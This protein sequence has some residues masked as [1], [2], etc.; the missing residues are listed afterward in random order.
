VLLTLSLFSEFEVAMQREEMQESLN[1][2]FISIG[3]IGLAPSIYAELSSAKISPETKYFPFV[4]AST[5]SILHIMMSLRSLSRAATRSIPRTV[6]Q[7]HPRAFSTIPRTSLLQ[8]TYKTVSIPRYAPFSTSRAF[9]EK[10]GQG[11]ALSVLYQRAQAH[12]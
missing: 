7:Y 4:K 10:E 3:D 9:R 8:Q 12:F 2:C 11:I 5:H 6:A 1:L